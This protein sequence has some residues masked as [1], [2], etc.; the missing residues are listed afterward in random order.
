M[1]VDG[2]KRRVP[3]GVGPLQVRVGNTVRGLQ[4]GR[5]GL[6]ECPVEGMGCLDGLGANAVALVKLDKVGDE[7]I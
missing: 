6:E 2:I 7:G 3:K 4:P 1:V 5:E